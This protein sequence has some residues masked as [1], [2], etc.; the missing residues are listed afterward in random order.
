M[1]VW[2][3]RNAVGLV[4]LG[5]VA[6]TLLCGLWQA[7]RNRAAY[8][9]ALLLAEAERAGVCSAS[10]ALLERGDDARLQSLLR[11]RLDAALRD[12]DRLAAEGARVERAA[13]VPNL[14]DALRRAGEY[15]RTQGRADAAAQAERAL[16]RLP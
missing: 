14:R 2:L 11:E 8:L 13:D 10:L 9:E 3:R 15:A 16:G 4:V 6:A 12:A 7:R 1:I 5:V